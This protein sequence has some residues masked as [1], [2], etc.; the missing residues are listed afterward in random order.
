MKISLWMF[1]IRGFEG[2]IRI[3]KH[4]GLR[5]SSRAGLLNLQTSKFS[6][7]FLMNQNLLIRVLNLRFRRG[8]WAPN[9]W[10]TLELPGPWFQIT[11][12]LYLV[13]FAYWVKIC[14]WVFAIWGFEGGIGPLAF[15]RSQNFTGALISNHQTSKFS[16]FCLKS[17]NLLVGICNLRFRRW[18]W[19]LNVWGTLKFCTRAWIGNHQTSIFSKFGSMSHHYYS[20]FWIWALD[21]GIGPHRVR[22]LKIRSGPRFQITKHLNLAISAQGT[23]CSCGCFEF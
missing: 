12:Y 13:F 23:T 2:G 4:G 8:N 1:K 9:M 14:W 22:N 16:L 20:G 7:F 17:V 10:G 3:P 21:G 19:T 18:N 6:L 5:N 15:W 11:E